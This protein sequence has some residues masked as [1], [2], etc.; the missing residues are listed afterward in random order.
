MTVLELIV[1]F[2]GYGADPEDDVTIGI[3]NEDI[4]IDRIELDYVENDQWVRIV[5]RPEK[6]D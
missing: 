2:M 1:D 6:A 3:G 4:P 5:P